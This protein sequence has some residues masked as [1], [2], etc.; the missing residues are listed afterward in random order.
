VFH[1]ATITLEGHAK[2]TRFGAMWECIPVLEVLSNNL[3]RLQ[4][5]YPLFTTFKTTDLTALD[6]PNDIQ[7]R[8]SG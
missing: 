5:E 2:D 1:T 8:A 4:D 6:I 3:I 7:E